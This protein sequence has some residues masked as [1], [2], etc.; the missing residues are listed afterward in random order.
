MGLYTTESEDYVETVSTTLDELRYWRQKLLSDRFEEKITRLEAVLSKSNNEVLSALQEYVNKSGIDGLDD[1][2]MMRLAQLEYD[3]ANF[4]MTEKMRQ[5]EGELNKYQAGSR[6]DMPALPAPDYAKTVYYAAELLHKFPNSPLSDRAH[7]LLGYCL[8]DEGKTE[9]AEKIY[10]RL[11][12]LHPYSDLAPEARF[13]LAESYFDDGKFQDALV[14]YR[15]LAQAKSAFS[16]KRLSIRKARLFTQA[17]NTQRAQKS[18]WNYSK[19]PV[20]I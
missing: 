13:R 7:Y 6:K 20:R 9:K 19:R 18:F 8:N 11:V 1:S 12:R 16:R 10:D 4:D 15:I 2:L 3:R 14:H 17:V 5:Y